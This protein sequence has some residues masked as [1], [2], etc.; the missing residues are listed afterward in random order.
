[1]NI[2]LAHKHLKKDPKIAPLIDKHTVNF[3]GV[4][5]NIFRDILESIISQQLSV[6]AASTITN[7]FV[8]LFPSQEKITPE[9]ILKINDETF[10]S[11][12]LSRQ[13]ISYL[14]SLS[15]FIVSEKL[16]LETLQNL[17]DEEIISQLT[18]VKG[19]GRWTAEMMLI[20]SFAR[21]DVF[22]VGDLGLRTA[23]SRIYGIDR[24]DHAAI[25]IISK[26]WS[27]YRTLASLYL[28]RSLD[29]E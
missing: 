8:E 1:M 14:R 20:S 12:G 7:R 9:E 15:E 29:N 21:E 16:V 28:W 4:S 10:R 19:I 2:S 22:S 17:P 26:A 13:K 18:Q 27:P 5:I 11:V 3:R 6:K 24:N 25:E 23:V